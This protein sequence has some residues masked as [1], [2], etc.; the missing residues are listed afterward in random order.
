VTA[1][2]TRIVTK[3]LRERPDDSWTLAAVRQSIRLAGDR[4][5]AA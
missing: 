3:R 5:A 4:L 1:T 2:E